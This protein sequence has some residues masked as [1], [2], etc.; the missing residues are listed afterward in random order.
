M[1]PAVNS[2]IQDCRHT[3][4]D[5][6]ATN[7]NNIANV[8]S[9]DFKRTRLILKNRAPQGVQARVETVDSPSNIRQKANSQ[10][11]ESAERSNGERAEELPESQVNA[12]LYQANLK[13][14]QTADEITAGLLHIK[15]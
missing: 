3:E 1:I 11:L 4:P 9:R 12:R 7:A 15:G 10:G 5:F 13:T 2:A 6:I 14:L 8:D